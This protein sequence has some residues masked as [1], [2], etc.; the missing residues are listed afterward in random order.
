MLWPM[1]NVVLAQN[2]SSY[3]LRVPTWRKSWLFF[4]LFF[5]F[6]WETTIT[7][8]RNEKNEEKKKKKKKFVQPPIQLLARNNVG[9]SWAVIG[10]AGG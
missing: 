3:V 8:E 2:C 7:G 4:Y 6:F 10:S 1:I 5:F 9:I